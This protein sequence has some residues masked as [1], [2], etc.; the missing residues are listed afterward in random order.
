[1]EF[2]SS[3]L[4]PCNFSDSELG[5]TVT[6]MISSKYGIGQIFMDKWPIFLGVGIVVIFALMIVFALYK[7]NSFEKFRFFK[8]KIDE[9]ERLLRQKRSSRST[10]RS[11]SRQD[12][13]AVEILS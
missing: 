1:M 2:L 13:P 4:F 5:H 8:N 7:T 3:F 10:M 11:F 6:N 9:E 12:S